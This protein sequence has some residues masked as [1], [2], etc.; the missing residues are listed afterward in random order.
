MTYAVVLE[1]A[2]DQGKLVAWH[3][4]RTAGLPLAAVAASVAS[5]G[6]GGGG[7]AADADTIITA[8]VRG[9]TVV[10]WR[11]QGPFLCVVLCLLSGS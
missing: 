10:F 6:G 8:Q 9:D 7:Q 1:A 2:S 4:A 5:A 3:R 11:G